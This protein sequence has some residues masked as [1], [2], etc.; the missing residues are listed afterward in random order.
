M[1][2]LM[3]SSPIAKIDKLACGCRQ[4]RQQHEGEE[5]EG[6]VAHPHQN[7]P[8]QAVAE[9]GEGERREHLMPG[10]PLH[11]IPIHLSDAGVR[12]DCPRHACERALYAM[13]QAS[14]VA[15]GACYSRKLFPLCVLRGSLCFTISLCCRV[16]R[17]CRMTFSSSLQTC[18]PPLGIIQASPVTQLTYLQRQYHWM[19]VGVLKMM[20]ASCTTWRWSPS[21]MTNRSPK[22]PKKIFPCQLHVPFPAAVFQ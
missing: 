9:E 17:A 19:G 12:K 15:L 1:R 11:W 21:F 3:I 8:Q 2:C 6:G 22:V 10:S 18:G 16:S 20:I 13:Q 5:E 7:Q 4:R 14:L